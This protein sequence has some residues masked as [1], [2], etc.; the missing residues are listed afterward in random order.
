[1]IVLTF[2]ANQHRVPLAA[3]GAF[4]AIVLVALAGLAARAP[5]ARV[6]ENTMKLGVG[7]MLTSFGTFWGAQ[8]AG[9]AWPGDDAALLAI[10]PAIALASLALTVRLR[11]LAHPAPTA[12]GVRADA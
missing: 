5:L 2:G 11:R 8:G 9:A 6:S 1:M 7:V 4:A 3:A 12:P 10:I